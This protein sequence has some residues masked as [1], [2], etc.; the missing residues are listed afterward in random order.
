M[1]FRK[2]PVVIEAIQF[3]DLSSINKMCNVWRDRFMDVADC[4][5]LARETLTKLRGGV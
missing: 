2:K 4:G 3:I 5:K 1:K